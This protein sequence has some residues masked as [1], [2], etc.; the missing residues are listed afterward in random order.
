M[1]NTTISY[2]RVKENA[3]T[4]KN[5]ST[6]MSKIFDDV[7]NTMKSLNSNEALVGRAGD[8]LLAK[9]NSFRGKFSSYTNTVER[10]ANLISHAETET[11]RTEREIEMT[12]DELA[13]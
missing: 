7:E 8:A 3:N 10:F 13:G 9:F 12:T 6:T 4:I 2:E 1:N 5:C 11:E